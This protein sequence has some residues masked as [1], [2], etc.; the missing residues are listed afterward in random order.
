MPGAAG[1]SKFVPTSTSPNRCKVGPCS[2]PSAP[3]ETR[4]VRGGLGF[5]AKVRTERVNQPEC[6]ILLSAGNMIFPK[7]EIPSSIFWEIH[8]SV[9]SCW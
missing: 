5:A 2:A 4:R 9:L 3:S 1:R 6:T 7:M 8:G